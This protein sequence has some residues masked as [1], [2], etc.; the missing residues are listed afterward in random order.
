[1]LDNLESLEQVRNVR[2]IVNTVTAGV[3]EGQPVVL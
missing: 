2:D 3:L 1:M